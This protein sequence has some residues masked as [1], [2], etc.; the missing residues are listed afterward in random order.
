MKAIFCWCD[1]CI[2][3]ITPLPGWNLFERKHKSSPSPSK[4]KLFWEHCK[5]G[6]LPTGP[7]RLARKILALIKVAENPNMYFALRDNKFTCKG[8]HMDTCPSLH[9]DDFAGQDNIFTAWIKT[10]FS[11][12]T[13]AISTF[14]FCDCFFLESVWFAPQGQQ[15]YFMLAS[16]KY[17]VSLFL[18]PPHWA[19]LKASAS[20]LHEANK[21]GAHSASAGIF[22]SRARLGHLLLGTFP[23][24]TS[25]MLA[26]QC[27]EKVL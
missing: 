8:I 13:K 19:G 22:I 15:S 21:H 23:M 16:S 7:D 1:S 3:S 4:A 25:Q 27:L 24:E 20:A 14:C 6:V 2:S 9:R 12:A 5:P 10:I 18:E 17:E 26:K 11:L